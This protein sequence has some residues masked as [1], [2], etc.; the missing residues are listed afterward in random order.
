[1]VEISSIVQEDLE[2]I[3][4]R[5]GADVA[6]F[7]GATVIVSGGCGFLG[8][9]IVGALLELNKL[10]P[11]NPC[12]VV[13]LDNYITSSRKNLIF[14]ESGPNY[15]FIECD[16][17]SPIPESINADYVIHAAGLASP[18][19]YRKFPIETIEVA[20]NGTKNFLEYARERPVKGMIFYSSSEIYGD[21]PPQMI[22]TPETY[23]GNISCLGP[24]ACYDESKRLGETL[25]NVYQSLYGVPVKII[26]PFNVYG[27]GGLADQDFRAIPTFISAGLAGK[28]MPVHG[29]GNQTRTFCY[30]TDAVVGFLKVLL[31]GKSGEAYNI[32]H[33]QDEMNMM[34][35]AHTIAGMIG[36][37][38][39]AELIDYPD[40][41]PA[42]EP[43]RRC[44]DLSKARS[45]LG[46]IPSVD[47]Q[48]GLKRTIEWYRAL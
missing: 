14:D 26:R 46:F 7:S 30:I 9:Y 45:E 19:Y 11:N 25:C 21:P 23:W 34:T 3:G 42:G 33:D 41:Y 43:Q 36:G 38:A 6:L 44:P 18:F 37:E 40:T 13:V 29:K 1:M 17:R 10:F 16:V 27:P 5:L 4:K 2:D 39:S 31:R 12:K 22:P 28:K 47:L 32:G 15:T 8:R 20:V 35:L 48:N 24:R